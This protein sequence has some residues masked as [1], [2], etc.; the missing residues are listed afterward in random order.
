V[1]ERSERAVERAAGPE[2]EA[3]SNPLLDRPAGMPDWLPHVDDERGVRRLRRIIVTV[4]VLG[5]LAFVVR[6]ADRPKDPTLGPATTATSAPAT[7][8]TP[9]TSAP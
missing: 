4:L 5:L 7:V 9:G 1:I 6:G 3:L 2:R 8:P